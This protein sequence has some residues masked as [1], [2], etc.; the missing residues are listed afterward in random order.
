VI[1]IILRAKNEMPWLKYTLRMLKAQK[2]QDFELICVDSGSTD[3]SWELL[4]EYAPDVLYQIAPEDYIPGRVLNNAIQH[5]KGEYIVFN[6]ADCIPLDRDWLENLVQPLREDPEVVAVFANQLARNDAIPLVQKDYERAFGDG[7]ISANWR[8]FFS[9]A[10]S[11]VRRD[12]ITQY[13]FNPD[14]QYSEDIEWSWRMKKMGHKI[15]YVPESRVE[16][17]HNYSLPQIKKRYFGEGKAEA[18]IYR[19]YYKEHPEDLSFFRSVMV[20]ATMEYLRDILYLSKIKRPDWLA[21]AKL[22]RFAQRYYAYQGRIAGLKD[23]AAKTSRLMVSCLAF[24][25]GKSGISDYTV[26]VIRELLKHE[27]LTL[28]IHPEDKAVFPLEDPKLSYEIVPQWLS[29]PIFS[30]IWH[31]YALPR[32]IAKRKW[33]MVFL[34]A[35]NRRLLAKYDVATAV[36]FHDLSQFHIPGKYDALRMYYIK[37]VIPHYLKKAPAVFAISESTKND[38]ILYYKMRPEQITL[39]YNGYNPDKLE[40][41]MPLAKLQEKFAIKGKYMLYIARIEHPGKNHLNLLKAYELLPEAIKE[42]YDLICGGG[43]WNNSEIVLDYHARMKDRDRVHFPGFVSGDDIA[44][45]YQN[46]SLYVFPS[47]Y[48]GFG[49]PLLEAFAAGIPVICSDRSSLPEIGAEAVRLFN[50]DEAQSI[51]DAIQTVLNDPTQQLQMILL[52]QERLKIFSWEKHAKIIIESLRDQ[53]KR[54]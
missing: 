39:N 7:R 38:M 36:T 1:S 24:D 40:T 19:E 23:C 34:P 48:E 2:N 8:H 14:I 21:K 16:H 42:E 51:A 11:A 15:R 29:R 20:A 49:I 35:G 26:N 9:L 50:P 37:K 43:K 27:A 28:L 12:I 17:S 52:G 31:L 32:L 22:Y 53:L 45:L 6:N 3:G 33:Q 13:P 46:A 47:L 4:Q 54:S 44:A 18:F 10:S 5:A 25:N 41:D 30:M